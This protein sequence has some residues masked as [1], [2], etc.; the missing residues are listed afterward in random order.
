V[1]WLNPWIEIRRSARRAPPHQDTV[2][3]QLSRA[4]DGSL[5][6]YTEYDGRLVIEACNTL[7]VG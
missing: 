2:G 6:L 3:S 1:L 5:T 7:D 4:Q